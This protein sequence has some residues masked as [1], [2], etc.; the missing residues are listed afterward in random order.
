[1]K[2]FIKENKKTTQG[3]EVWVTYLKHELEY[4]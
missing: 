2:Y 3:G 4:K 1:L